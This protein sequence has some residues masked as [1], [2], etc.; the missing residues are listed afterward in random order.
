MTAAAERVAGIAERLPALVERA[1]ERAR[2]TKEAVLVSVVERLPAVD[3][4]DALCRWWGEDPTAE[5][6]YWERPAQGVA[7]VGVGS[8]ATFIPGGV[9]RFS[10]ADDLAS[11]LLAGAI[12]D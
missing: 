7:L 3:P 11:T 8:V 9:E 1:R 4:L 5:R 12:I 6:M 2:E 10:S